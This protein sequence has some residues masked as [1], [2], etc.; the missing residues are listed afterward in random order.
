MTVRLLNGINPTPTTEN[1]LSSGQEK[2]NM[3]DELSFRQGYYCALATIMRQHDEPVVVKD[4]LLAYGKF[5][6][7]GIEPYD[8]EVLKPVLKSS[9]EGVRSNRKK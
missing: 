7:A 1:D 8:L 6:P 3:S 5:I 2:V 9:S 4:A